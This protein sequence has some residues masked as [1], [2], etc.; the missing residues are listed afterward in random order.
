MSAIKNHFYYV[1]YGV[2]KKSNVRNLK[3]NR[4]LKIHPDKYG[5]YYVHVCQNGKG[6][7]VR[8]S[9]FVWECHHGQ[10]PHGLVIDHIDNHKDNNRIENLQCISQSQN[11]K[12]KFTDGNV[13]NTQKKRIQ[14]THINTGNK[15]IFGSIYGASKVLNII[16]A[17]INR[18]C[19]GHQKSAISKDTNQ[20]YHFKVIS[21]SVWNFEEMICRHN[22][23]LAENADLKKAREAQK[24]MSTEEFKELCLNALRKQIF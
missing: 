15:I 14:A 12:K 16:P 8:L 22:R 4:K 5:Y 1:N 11:S 2:D 17:S 20:H 3:T 21:E 19:S 13:I 24:K 6:N 23:L 10:I 7:N 18:V 9:R